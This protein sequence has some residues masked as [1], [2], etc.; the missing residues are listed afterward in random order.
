MVLWGY[1]KAGLDTPTDNQSI[2]LPPPPLTADQ[3]GSFL[4]TAS[5]DSMWTLSSDSKFPSAAMRVS[6]LVAYPWD[7]LA[8]IQDDAEEDDTLHALESVEK[9][10]ALLNPR[11]I[12]NIGVLVVLIGCLLCLFIVLPVVTYVQNSAHSLF[13]EEGSGNIIDVAQGA[14]LSDPDAV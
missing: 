4:S 2:L 12:S 9:P 10:P 3:R 13:I 14:S 6:G 7:P 11:S 5:R 1:S 8:D